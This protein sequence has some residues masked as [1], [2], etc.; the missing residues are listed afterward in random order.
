MTMKTQNH[1]PKRAKLHQCSVALVCQDA[2][3]LYQQVLEVSDVYDTVHSTGSDAPKKH[4][5]VSSIFH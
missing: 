3:L 2:L 5:C 1:A 4:T